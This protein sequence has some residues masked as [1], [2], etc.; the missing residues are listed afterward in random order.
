MTTSKQQI[1]TLCPMNC[2]PTHCGMI[3]EVTDNRVTSIKGDPQNPDSRGF[4]CL[5]GQATHEIPGNPRR[6]LTPL[7]RIGPRGS[8]RWEP[9]SWDDAYA[10]IVERIQQTR[11]DRVGI[12]MGHGALTTSSIRPLIMR[13][14]YLG[15]LQVWNPAVICWALGAYGLALTGVLE[16][17]TKEDMAAYSR[18]IFFWGATLASQ[19]STAPH[20]IAARKRG[21]HVIAI[22]CRKGDIARHADEV[23]LIK[24]GS[25]AALAL[26]MAH[27]IV[28]DDLTNPAFIREH[29]LG[30]EAFSQHLLTFTPEW[31]EPITGIAAERI[32][33][34]ARQYATNTPAMI[35]L[36]GSSMF[37]HSSGWEASRA[38][39]CLP[40][41]T[42]QLGIAGGG[43]G[44]RHRAFVHADGQTDLQALDRRPPGEY[45]PNSMPLITTA[46]QDGRLDV[47]FVLGS[48][49]LSSFADGNTIEHGLQRV[50]LVVA[51]DIFMNETIR[52]C[53]DLVLPG[54]IWLE[55]LGLKDTATHIYLMERALSA[56]GEKNG[57]PLLRIL[58]D[59]ADRLAIPDYFPWQDQEDYLNALLAPQQ[60]SEG[61]SLTLADLR[62]MGGIWQKSNLSHISYPDQRFHTPSGKVEFWSE[63]AH[64]VGLSPLP[65]YTSLQQD[66][67]SPYP[68]QFRQGRTLTAFHSF[69]D[70]GQALPTLA[71][72]NAEPELWI[73]PFDAQQ[74]QIAPNNPIQIYNERGRFSARARITDDVPP[75]VVWMRDGWTGVNRV[76]NGN[77]ILPIPALSIVD[78]SM[79]PGGQSAFDAQVEV[80]KV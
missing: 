24:P 46:L 16:A 54:T 49:M 69:Y 75:G 8:D 5:R 72:A 73:H 39:A 45:L 20:L 6:L 55:E 14:G 30:F 26:A 7:Q 58:R 15:G 33:S 48:N 62:Q 21:A 40:A 50:G 23:V 79:I 25:D 44:P 27:V 67:E 41:L 32:R 80:C 57:R 47:F 64:S 78:P 2:N 71:K 61:R 19:P 77:P 18:T 17:N 36:G 60:T 53:A 28:T 4:L 70:E 65:T 63:R 29:T 43:L 76:T 74:R 34:L 38:I 3:V 52:R 66:A 68:L 42:G 10:L 31:A 13:F 12:W 35:V 59:L 1:R 51:Y 11:R 56:E 9:I 22:D 37:K